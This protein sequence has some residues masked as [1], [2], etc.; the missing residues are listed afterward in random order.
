MNESVGKQE[1]SVI[2]EIPLENMANSPTRIESREVSVRPHSNQS[3]H[4]A[5]SGNS[6]H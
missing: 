4:S 2:V 1:A 3:R 6:G 5:H